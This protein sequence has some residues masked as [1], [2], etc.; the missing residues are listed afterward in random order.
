MGNALLRHEYAY[1]ASV[2]FSVKASAYSGS[3]LL[4]IPVRWDKLCVLEA[5]GK[6][7]MEHGELIPCGVASNTLPDYVQWIGSGQRT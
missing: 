4:D 5:Y 1:K 3:V 7:G 2:H 6:Y